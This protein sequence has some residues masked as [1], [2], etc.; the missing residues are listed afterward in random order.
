MGR[1]K[2]VDELP[3]QDA[4]ALI[5]S[6]QPNGKFPDHAERAAAAAIVGLLGRFTLAVERPAVFLG[7][8]AED[9]SCV[10]FRDRLKKE[11]L[12]GLETAAGETSEGVRHGEELLTASLRA[13]LERRATRK[14]W[15]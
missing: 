10:G 14:D 7:Q 6:H 3:E 4:V 13:I 12:V 11:G 5:Q 15:C 2:D 9:V 1:Q 8:F